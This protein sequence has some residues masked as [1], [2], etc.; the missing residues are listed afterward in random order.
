M[1]ENRNV[2]QWLSSLITSLALAGSTS[3]CLAEG[4]IA[5][6]FNSGASSI[7][8]FG[9]DW[10]G[11]VEWSDTNGVGGS[12]CLKVTLSENGGAG[13]E[14]TPKWTF[15][16]GPLQTSQY[17]QVEYDL[18]FD[19]GSG[20][21]AGGSFGNY[22]EVFR[23][24]SG[25]WEG[26]WVGAIYPGSYT[27]W[28]HMSVAVPNNGKQYPSMD[29]VL[30]GTEPY[31]SDV[32]FYIDNIVV[33]PVPNP[34]VWDAFT[35]DI[36]GWA[37]ENWTGVA[38]TASWNTSE[39]AGGGYTPL[40]SLQLSNSF[41]SGWQQ[42]WQT[43]SV[44]WAPNRW[45]T[46]E[47]D[48]KVDGANSMANEDGS[49]GQMQVS[50][51]DPNWADHILPPGAFTLSSNYTS[52][53]HVALSLPNDPTNSSSPQ[54]C[55]EF[56]GS[57]AGPVQVFVDN[58]RLTTPITPPKIYGLQPGTPG[59]VKVF[60]DANGT[61]HQWDQEAFTSPSADNNARNFFP[62]Y[63]SPASYSFTISQF[64]DAK[65]APGFQAH[66]YLINGDSITAGG[67]SFAWNQTYSGAPWNAYD[68][69]GFLV[70]N[71]TGATNS[72][73][74]GVI[75]TFEWKTNSPSGGATNRM[76][77]Q[78]PQY[79]SANGTWTLN[80][81][82]NTH[83]AIV[84]P[85]GAVAG[86]ID[87]PDFPSDPNYAG[88]FT[89]F[90]SCIQFG[91][92]KNDTDNTGVN[93]NQSAYFNHVVVTNSGGVVYDDTFGGPGLTANYAWQTATDWQF[94]ANRVLWQPAGTAFWLNYGD[95]SSGYTFQVA[96]SLAGPWADAG[97]VYSY[98]DASGTNHFGAVPTANLP[99]GNT[100][101]FRMVK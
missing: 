44:P 50:V 36:S 59:G 53:Q 14:T 57:H 67:G 80:F 41:T 77:F 65:V 37:Q 90:T 60:V 6:D 7:S 15:P 29:W 78:L 93:N 89:P 21:D 11:S 58:I 39:D 52:W 81:S 16:G 98:S 1:I 48:I 54:L 66:L 49:Y 40:G 84:G 92:A 32:V 88:N 18:R 69:M 4:T 76:V 9:T 8:D 22:Q 27:D 55:L 51:R 79:T 19:A 12:G 72:V 47:Y 64:P 85:D 45:T 24:A 86:T 74:N 82:D 42:S 30:Q 28:T 35:N 20:T 71:G 31:T 43:H 25:S 96:G 91:V 3:F 68:Y 34:Y 99:A 100:G 63:Q 97:V 2:Q 38:G 75:A 5:Q 94:G 56:V 46:F 73:T 10:A 70:E 13:K 26:H 61:S 83:G 87:L 62:I 101:F 23:D 95:P 33:T 17:L